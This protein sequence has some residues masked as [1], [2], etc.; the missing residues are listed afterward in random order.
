MANEKDDLLVRVEMA[1]A[2]QRELDLDLQ[3]TGVCCELVVTNHSG[4]TRQRVAPG[5]LRYN[6]VT[7]EY[8][9]GPSAEDVSA[10]EKSRAEMANKAFVRAWHKLGK[11][12]LQE[13]A[14]AQLDSLIDAL[15]A[16]VCVQPEGTR[17]SGECGC[18]V[19]PNYVRIG[20][21]WCDYRPVPIESQPERACRGAAEGAVCHG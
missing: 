13:M 16:P 14:R 19:W 15:A 12:H 2:R 17:L 4:V 18:Q 11:A 5:L 3:Y 10:Y 20:E 1:Q 7:G 6:S 9:I 21:D 8:A